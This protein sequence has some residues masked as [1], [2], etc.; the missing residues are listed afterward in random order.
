MRARRH[1]RRLLLLCSV[2]VAGALAIPALALADSPN[3]TTL[4]ASIATNANGT[5]TVTV[6]GTWDWTAVTCNATNDRKTVGFAIDWNDPDQPGNPV[7]D[8]FDVGTLAANANNPAD[9]LVHPANG[10]SFTVCNTLTGAWGSLSHTY[11]ANVSEFTMCVVMYDVHIKDGIAT[12]GSHSTQAGGLNHNIDNSIEENHTTSGSACQGVSSTAVQLRSFTASRSAKSLR[13]N[14]RTASEIDVLGYNLYG[15]VHGKR[16]RLNA[17]LIA[18]RGSG[19][20]CVF[21]PVQVGARTGGS[22]SVL[23]SDREP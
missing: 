8:G 23:A 1:V 7:A 13:L 4:S 14:W 3:P 5:K 11:A 20:E 19:S 10:S 17:R 21:L 16:V 6:S 18:S 15:L 12:T 2:V 9:N 22:D